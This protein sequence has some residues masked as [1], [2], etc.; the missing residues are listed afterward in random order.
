M[1]G[2]TREDIKEAKGILIDIGLIIE[3]GNRNY[4]EYLQEC[5]YE[6]MSIRLN[7]FIRNLLNKEQ[8]E[9]EQLIERIL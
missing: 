3:F 4:K 7:L 5:I 6:P 2:L 8:F 9:I 1:E